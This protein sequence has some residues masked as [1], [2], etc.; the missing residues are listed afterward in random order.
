MK[1]VDIATLKD[2]VIYIAKL[3]NGFTTF[4]INCYF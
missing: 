1:Q 2:S 4:Y 3:P